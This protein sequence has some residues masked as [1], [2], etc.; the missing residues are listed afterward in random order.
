[1]LLVLNALPYHMRKQALRY[2]LVR[3]RIGETG[4]SAVYANMVG[5]QDELIFDGASFAMNSKGDLTHQFDEFGETLGLIELQDGTPIS[6][7]IAASNTLEASV[8]QA[9]CLGVKDYVGKNGIPGVLLGLSGGVD[10]ALTMAIAVDALGAEVSESGND[11]FTIY[12]RYKLIGCAYH[13]PDVG[14]RL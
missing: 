14:C 11:A 1:M 5:G 9:L 13:G 12:R 10:S 8:Y 3:Q 6:G 7:Y 2:Q 4:L